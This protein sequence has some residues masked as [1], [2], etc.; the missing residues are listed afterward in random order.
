MIG[1][2]VVIGLL[3]LFVACAADGG[4]TCP[5]ATRP[6]LTRCDKYFRCVQLPSGSFV[7]IPNQCDTGLIYEVNLKMCV[8]PGEDWECTLPGDQS[9]TIS[10]D[11]NIYGVNNLEYL[12]EQLGPY[13]EEHSSEVTISQEPQLADFSEDEFSGDG[14]P[15]II[16]DRI[17]EEKIGLLPLPISSTTDSELSTHLQRL[18]QLIDNFHKNQTKPAVPVLHPDDLNSF[19]ALHNIRHQATI[20]N[21]SNKIPLPE[22]GMIHP[23]T[24]NQILAQQNQLHNNGQMVKNGQ[25]MNRVKQ[26]FSNDGTTIHIK[27]A[28]P[29]KSPFHPDSYSNSQIVVNRP[30]GA[31]LFNVARPRDTLNSQQSPEPYISEN[32]LKTVLELSKQLVSSHP[33]PLP[34]IVPPVIYTIPIPYPQALHIP[35]ETKDTKKMEKNN[36]TNMKDSPEA[37]SVTVKEPLSTSTPLPP[38]NYYVDSYGVKYT[39]Q[40]DSFPLSY[41]T[42]PNYYP[43]YPPLTYSVPSTYSNYP[44]DSQ[45]ASSY[46]N[47]DIYSGQ[48]H[49]YP[50]YDGLSPPSYGATS[51]YQLY[52]PTIVSGPGGQQQPA[53]YFG[54]NDGNTQSMQSSNNWRGDDYEEQDEEEGSMDNTEDDVSDDTGEQMESKESLLEAIEAL[55]KPSEPP[56]GFADVANQLLDGG[57]KNKVINLKGNYFNYE[58]YRDTIL[59][60]LSDTDGSLASSIEI[61]SCSMG[62]RQPNTTD[63]TRYFV[64]N[65]KTGD[66]LSYSCPPFTGFNAQSKICDA[67]TYALCNPAAVQNRFTISEN[68]RIQYEA[69]KALEEAKKIRDEAIRAQKL[70][71]LLRLQTQ[72]SIK[73]TA[74]MQ[75]SKPVVIPQRVQSTRRPTKVRPSSSG[76]R[77]KKKRYRC[78][79]DGG[80]VPDTASIFKY[81]VCYKGSNGKWR[82]HFMTCSKGLVFC[83]RMRKCTLQRKCGK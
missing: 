40:V 65:P 39:P 56:P 21:N 73:Q 48:G 36:A 16:T 60:L 25:T 23:D 64:C 26:K 81:I 17:V 9:A 46:T 57:G 79:T 72:N 47:Q 28:G 30:E 34:P 68:K 78:E 49:S 12:S 51:H 5:E 52:G 13:P 1:V 18:T 70:A 32:T 11:S 15:E 67:R 82:R 55:T 76:T 74:S 69:Q 83:T 41:S 43:P 77:V 38:L 3:G 20:F 14:D 2:K 53:N 4:K 71:A 33:P 31:V 19:L 59:P 42:G 61:L 37:I 10:D 58:T 27:S 80:A 22:N 54:Y 62:V 6:H 7:W 44:I 29:P 75:M 8:L 63:C 35:K 24:M 50:M 66:L 45:S